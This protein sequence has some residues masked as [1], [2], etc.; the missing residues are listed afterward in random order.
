MPSKTWKI[1]FVVK[2]SQDKQE[3][4][5]SG[6]HILDAILAPR[7]LEGVTIESVRYKEVENGEE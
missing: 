7:L 1:T 4:L 6:T 5:L 2:D 3:D